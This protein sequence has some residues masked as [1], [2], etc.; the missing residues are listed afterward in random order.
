MNENENEREL[1][2]IDVNTTQNTPPTRT[3]EVVISP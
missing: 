1:P 3:L 2:L